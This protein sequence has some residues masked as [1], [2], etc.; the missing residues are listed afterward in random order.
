MTTVSQKNVHS[1]TTA[2][3]NGVSS[4]DNSVAEETEAHK[5]HERPQCY[6]SNAQQSL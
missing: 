5:P 3:H 6:N 1:A 4:R 2:M